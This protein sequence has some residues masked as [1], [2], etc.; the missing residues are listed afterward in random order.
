MQLFSQKSLLKIIY[1]VHRS[2]RSTNKIPKYTNVYIIYQ[3]AGTDIITK[4]ILKCIQHFIYVYA[5]LDNFGMS[6]TI[7][8]RSS[9]FLNGLVM[10]LGI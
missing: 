7:V 1:T 5:L 8:S 10:L 4:K 6:W 9:N 3:S 2:K